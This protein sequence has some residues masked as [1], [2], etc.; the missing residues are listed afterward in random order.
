MTSHAHRSI[1]NKLRR[2]ILLT[3]LVSLL[4]AMLAVLGIQALAYRSALLQ[5]VSVLVQAIG[6]TTTAALEFG[7]RKAATQLLEALRAE[8]EVSDG[9]LLDNA[10]GLVAVY[11]PEHPGTGETA[12]AGLRDR[13]LPT[14]ISAALASGEKAYAFS[15][16]GLVY[17]APIRFDGERIGWVAIKSSLN[18]LYASLRGNAALLIAV[19]LVATGLAHLVASWLQRRISDPIFRLAADM[20][21]VSIEQDYSLRALPGEDDEIGRLIDGFNSMLEQLG[22]RDRRLAE[23]RQLLERE[24]AERTADLT[25]A[26]EAAQIARG[27][28]EQAREV[29]EQASRAKSQFLANMSHEIRTP[30]NGVVGMSELLLGTD[31]T[32]EQRRFAGGITRSGRSLLTV[33][34]DILDVSKIEAGRMMLDCADFDLEE[35]IEEVVDL[36]AERA[37]ANSLELA[38]RL[39]PDLPYRV[40]GDPD[41]IAQILSNLIGNAIKFTESGEVSVRVDLQSHDERQVWILVE[42]VDS[43]IG[44]PLDRQS[45]VFDAFAQVD[46]SSSRAFGGTGLG[47]AI[48]KELTELMGGMIG[49]ESDGCTGSCFWFSIPMEVVD[50]ASPIGD[51]YPD[52]AGRR[53]LL[54]EPHGI[55]RSTIVAHAARAGLEVKECVDVDGALATLRD[56]EALGMRFDFVIMDASLSG[57]D[58]F[59]DLAEAQVAYS[60]RDIP[61]ILL[62]PVSLVC[63]S[64][65]HLGL[66]IDAYLCKPIGRRRL[67]ACLQDILAEETDGAGDRHG[68]ASG[69]AR[70]P[71]LGL[72]VLVAEDNPVNQQLAAAMLKAIGCSVRIVADG[73]A[74]IDASAQG[75]FDL[76]LM[77]CQMPRVDGYEATRRIRRRE[78]VESLARLPIIAL[79]AHAMSGDQERCLAAGMDDYLAKPVMLSMLHRLLL[80]W[81]GQPDSGMTRSVASSADDAPKMPQLDASSDWAARPLLAASVLDALCA[82]VEGCD[83]NLRARL[84]GTF[85]ESSALL[86]A[87]LVTGI[88]ETDPR[89]AIEA[90]HALRSAA[91]NVGAERLAVLCAQIECVAGEGE[92]LGVGQF[93]VEFLM[94]FQ[95]VLDETRSMLKARLVSDAEVRVPPPRVGASAE[96]GELHSDAG[97]RILVVDDDPTV[98]LLA[99]TYLT[100][101]GFSVSEALDGR[102]AIASVRS[103]RPDLV[104]LDVMMPGLDGFETCR[105]LRD[106]PGVELVPILMVTGLDDIASI[107]RAY[108]SGATDF[109]AKPIN[110]SLI[111]HRIRYLLRGHATLAAL[112]RSEARNSAL[113]SAIPDA[114]LRL[115]AEGRILHFKPGRAILG[116]DG[117]SAQVV[118]DLSDLLPESVAG[119]IR[120]EIR[121]TL[122]E[123]AMRELE[124]ELPGSD[125][126]MVAFDAR[127]IAIDDQQV[128][129]LLRD[130][131]E[132]RRRQRVIHQLAYRDGLTGLA[133]RRQFNQDL[134]DALADT[135]RQ[136]DHV[137][138]LFLDLDEFK[139]INDSLG[140]GIGD[141]LL[142]AAAARLQSAVESVT[143]GATGALRT[144]V[145]RLGGDELTVIICGSRADQVARE[146][147]ERIV[148]GFREPFVCSGQDIVCTVSVGIALCPE[149]GETFELL[150]KHA[151]TAMYAAKVKG[152]NTYRFFTP[153]MGEAASRKLDIEARLRRGIERGE[154]LI[155]YQPVVDIASGEILSLEA[156]LRWQEPEQG[157]VGPD[158]F[159][160]VAE[161]SGLILPLGQWVIDEVGRQLER[162]S[163]QGLDL[164]VGINLSA[165]Q[166]VQPELIEQ[167]LGVA[168]GLRP[169][170]IEIEIT[171]SLLLDQNVGLI[172]NLAR[173]RAGGVRVAIDDFGTGY[174]SL[175]YLQ[176]LP[177]DTLKIDRRFVREIGQAHPSDPVVRTIIALGQGLGLRI[178]AEGVESEAQLDFLVREGCQAVQGYLFARP[179]SLSQLSTYLLR[180]DA[181]SRI[182]RGLAST[183][184]I[185]PISS[186]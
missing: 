92:T 2:I 11:P 38:C 170:A 186:D 73:Q 130:I 114:L 135:R 172:D 49:L 15:R 22:E 87:N 175:S 88:G 62:V 79:T 45:Q 123:H 52:L 124:I 119:T 145:A 133:N 111:V 128:I 117:T 65:R 66:S 50:W 67:F 156:L 28:A 13:A 23:H 121:A 53:L 142:R 89:L 44:I 46:G 178:V 174:S 31:L 39:S 184:E 51:A 166:F 75:G 101:A 127:L 139:R 176:N 58:T 57:L 85:L 105:M 183:S 96:I 64:D 69:K 55:T 29:A 169:G 113:I 1:S 47:L 95:E 97:P 107:E 43:G 19:L 86:G 30:L 141:E 122:S 149:H 140:H 167:V 131:T 5:H 108:E 16:D 21:R 35:L 90:A 17:V 76:I 100:E 132:R 148:D 146:V 93:L 3:T 42:V 8:P 59:A 34:N 115:D 126:E 125:T 37:H 159:I 74:A 91:A 26:V 27:S 177:I 181:R 41:R 155:H 109:L 77:D 134:A 40:K 25:Q 20:D 94:P 118:G 110:W 81:S 10:G 72:R 63:Q 168:A 161:E 68:E 164:G 120:H 6:T 80:R 182:A 112:H 129:L 160:S 116:L 48:A 103:G 56:D 61:L 144:T 32:P 102:S 71:P 18:G 54:V 153:S 136:D 157:L 24:V 7:D 171:E 78:E 33:I 83:P 154:F 60:F 137:A 151:D 185:E 158:A 180:G 70:L 143:S 162:W 12:A 147:A 138:L 106:L 84:I 163:H 14:W 82:M 150:L 173:L 179:L 36:F 104:V 152:R 98:Q 99:S 4:V 9:W 165:R